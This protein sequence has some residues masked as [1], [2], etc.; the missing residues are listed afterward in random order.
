MNSYVLELISINKS[1]TTSK[2]FYFYSSFNSLYSLVL[3][4]TKI[5]FLV[6][7]FSSNFFSTITYF[8]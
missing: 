6:S 5:E 2:K 4:L 7:F 8:S 1:K 3:I